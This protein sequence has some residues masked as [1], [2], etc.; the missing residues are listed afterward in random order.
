[1]L[2]FEL[3]T[4]RPDGGHERRIEMLRDEEFVQRPEGECLLSPVRRWGGVGTWMGMRMP[5]WVVHWLK[6]KRYRLG[7]TRK[8]VEEGGNPYAVRNEWE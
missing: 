2:V 7:K 8:V 5:R 4:D 6:G 1:L 3:E